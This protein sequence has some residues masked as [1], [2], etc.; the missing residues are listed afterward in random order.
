MIGYPISY[1][2]LEAL[3][4]QEKATWISRAADRTERFR[5]LGRYSESSTIW[6]EIKAVYMTLQG[7]SKC[8]YCERK[9]ESIEHGRGEQDIEHFR[10]K[11]NVK[12]WIAPLQITSQGIEPAT[13]PNETKG[14]YLLP[15]HIFNYAAACKPCNSNLKGDRFPIAG[16]YDLSGEDPVALLSEQPYL[17][18]PIGDFD[19][20]PESLVKFHGVSPQ[21]VATDGFDRDRALVTIEFF[22]LDDIR[23][24]NL[25]R[26]RIMIITALFPQLE[27]I[28]DGANDEDMN[29]AERVLEIYKSPKSPHTNCA[30]SFV[31]LHESD[32]ARAR[33]VYFSALDFFDSTS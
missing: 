2:E 14:Y 4:N 19:R 32:R 16:E 10:P 13:A 28:A 18:Y 9:L 25:I 12:D 26:E 6:S 24:K 22:K 20:D 7:E 11:G 30:R 15:Y 29:S 1:E 23:R 33:E 8:A 5:T 27:I 3:V 21:P 31:A 17:I